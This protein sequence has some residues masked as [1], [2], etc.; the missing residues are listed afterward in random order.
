VLVL[1]YCRLSTRVVFSLWLL[2]VIFVIV[3][4]LTTPLLY[5][6]AIPVGAAILGLV[7]KFRSSVARVARHKRF[8]AALAVLAAVLLT[9]GVIQSPPWGPEEHFSFNTGQQ[10][11][12]YLLAQTDKVTTIL[13]AKPRAIAYY[14]TGSLTSQYACKSVPWYGFSAIYYLPGFDPVRYPSCTPKTTQKR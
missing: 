9:L 13:L 12:G 14:D 1:L 10:V 2:T 4:A 7:G 11:T 5:L 6:A 3:A 8:G